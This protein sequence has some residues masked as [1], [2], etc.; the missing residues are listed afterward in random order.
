MLTQLTLRPAPRAARAA[1]AA[2]SLCTTTPRA[3]PSANRDPI[4]PPI[5]YDPAFDAS[6]AAGHK[7]FDENGYGGVGRIE[8][9]VQWGDSDMFQ[10]T[11]NVSY[12]RYLESAR[13]RFALTLAPELGQETAENWMYGRGTGWILK[14]QTI[15]YRRPVTYPDSL[16][17]APKITALDQARASFTLSHAAWSVKENAVAVTADSFAVMYDFDKLKKGVMSDRIREVLE[18]V[19]VQEA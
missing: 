10:H 16:I 3:S 14:E 18:K 2:R 7:W 4:P 11:N 13:V 12:V 5:Q 1:L 6:R 8:W 9:P 17:W 19:G 15:R